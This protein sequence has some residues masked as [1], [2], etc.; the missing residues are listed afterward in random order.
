MKKEKIKSL[1]RQQSLQ[2]AAQTTSKAITTVYM[3]GSRNIKKHSHQHNRTR[4]F[5]PRTEVCIRSRVR[6]DSYSLRAV[7]IASRKKLYIL[8]MKRRREEKKKQ[9]QQVAVGD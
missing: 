3:S 5:I 2:L 9:Q 4:R 7:H 6:V 8:K 1:G